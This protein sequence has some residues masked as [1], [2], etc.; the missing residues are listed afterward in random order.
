VEKHG[1]GNTT[2]H[3]HQRAISDSRTHSAAVVDGKA[4]VDGM[5]LWK[6]KWKNKAK[7]AKKKE[8]KKGEK[9]RKKGGQKGTAQVEMKKKKG[10]KAPCSLPLSLFFPLLTFLSLFLGEERT[11]NER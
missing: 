11:A 9:K 10:E 5:K 8:R 6:I 2:P 4:M 3:Q 1:S 7:K